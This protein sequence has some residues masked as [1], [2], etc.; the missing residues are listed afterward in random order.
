MTS[1]NILR[2]F[3]LTSLLRHRYRIAL[4]LLSASALALPPVRA[5]NSTLKEPPNEPILIL[6]PMMVEST[7]FPLRWRY[8]ELPGSEVLSVCDDEVT[9]KFAE[10][11]LRLEFLL[12]QVLPTRFQAKSDVPEK[13]IVFNE[14]LNRA[15]SQEVMQEMMR[16]AGGKMPQ[17][18]ERSIFPWQSGASGAPWVKLKMQLL[19]NLRLRDADTTIVF[20]SSTRRKPR[21]ISPTRSTASSNC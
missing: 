10:R 5:V 14:K 13:L 11:C 19:P 6:P 12:R 15:R 17:P 9:L 3:R 1:V 2:Q 8:L 20:T 4:I 16:R 18:E 7:G 21:W